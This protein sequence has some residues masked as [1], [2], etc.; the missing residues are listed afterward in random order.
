MAHNVQSL[1]GSPAVQDQTRGGDGWIKQWWRSAWERRAQRITLE[2][3]Q[4]LDDRTLQDIGLHRS[5]AGSVVYG[6]PKDRRL[7]FHIDG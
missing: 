4:S 6:A 5:E 7:P 1:M 3:L 2:L